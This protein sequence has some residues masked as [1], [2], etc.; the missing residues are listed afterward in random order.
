M[1]ALHSEKRIQSTYWLEGLHCANCAAKIEQAAANMDG[2]FNAAMDFAGGKIVVDSAESR[3]DRLRDELQRIA[4]QIEPG[5]KVSE[6]RPDKHAST[7]SHEHAGGH[8]TLAIIAA[9]LVLFAGGLALPIPQMFKNILLL[10]SY[11]AAGYPVLR[12]AW[13][14]LRRGQVF[15]ENFLMSVATFGA[16]A[17]NEIPEAAAV[18]LFYRTGEYLQDL[19]VDRSRRSITALI[20]IRP[21]EARVVYGSETRQVPVEQ[22]QPGDELV[23]QPGERVPVD[24]TITSGLSSFDTAALTGES[25]PKDA[26]EGDQVL[27]GYINLSGLLR[28]RADRPASKSAIA[29]IL[30]LVENAAAR[31]APTEEF[32]TKFARYYTPVVVAIAA[33][34]AIVPP[35]FMADAAFSDWLY[36]ALVFLVISCPCALVVS[37]PLGFFGGIGAASKAGVLVKG[38]NYLQA[39]H[40]LDTVVFDKTGTLTSGRFVVND[41]KSV[42]GVDQDFVLEMAAMAESASRHPIALSIREA[43]NQEIAADAIEEF[44]DMAGFGISARIN[45]QEVVCG[46]TRLME[47]LGIT[48]EFF[49]HKGQAVH[50]AVDGRYIGAVLLTD[51]PKPDSK[52]AV[53]R[54]RQL[55]IAKTIMLT[56]DSAHAASEAGESLGITDVRSELLPQ[57]KLTELEKI[58]AKSDKGRTAFVGDGINDAPVLAR[59]DVGIAMG[60]LGQDAAIEAADI[61]IMTDEPSKVADAIEIAGRTNRIVWQN[62]A[63]ALGVKFLVLA[64]GAFGHATLWEAV[65][66]DVGVTLLA[67][68]NSVRTTRLPSRT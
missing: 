45:G 30:N 53:T 49:A 59:A 42:E 47:H 29:R 28:I 9:A 58:M 50:V 54:L 16:L 65:F 31:K 39:L 66:A 22:V 36:R 62:I 24:G 15:D 64:M 34:L 33:L 37:I 44:Q 48:G 46:S 5:I 38:S 13:L 25:A 23:V 52:Q 60:G 57:D 32:I 1:S 4:D 19:A 40:E 10:V 43:Y 61:V 21:D 2:V 11:I 3:Q 68:L 12:S 55:G 67:V 6:K 8:N 63:L 27:A 26:G 51:T 17:I 35:I 18:M 14:N 41:V 56:G 7:H 20:A